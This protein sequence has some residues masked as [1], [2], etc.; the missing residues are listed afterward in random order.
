MTHP[1]YPADYGTV[2]L[3]GHCGVLATAILAGVP[4]EKAWNTLAPYYAA[5][6]RKWTGGT[7]HLHR[8]AALETLGVPCKHRQHVPAGDLQWLRMMKSP[9]L[10][11]YLPRCSVET[12][13]RRYAKPGV[14][15]MVCV[16][17]H[18]V[19]VRDGIV[20]DQTQAAPA[21]QHRS[22]RQLVRW[23]TE[24]LDA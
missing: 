21:S 14:T 20:I 23:S 3:W 5:G 18:V 11:D 13:A 22:R 16:S 10:A 7:H 1:L 2:P 9:S 4:F 6:R 8:K 19:T 15:Y 17:R 12:F 24:R